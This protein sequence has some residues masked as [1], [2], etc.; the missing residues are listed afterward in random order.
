MRAVHVGEVDIGGGKKDVA[1]VGMCGEPWKVDIGSW[2]D[3]AIAWGK[4]WDSEGVNALTKG[5]GKGGGKVCFGCGE[6]GH[7]ARECPV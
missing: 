2:G 3:E 4:G 7:F 6:P 5:G 1:A